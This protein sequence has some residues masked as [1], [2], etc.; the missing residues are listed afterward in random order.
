M[1]VGSRCP[2]VVQVVFVIDTSG[3]IGQLRFQLIREFLTTFTTDL[4][5]NS[6]RNAVGIILF[7]NNAYLEFNLQAYT[8]L[9]ELLLAIRQLPYRGGGTDTAE[10]LTLL[11]ST[12]QNGSL[13]L[14]SDS[15]NIAIVI[16]DGRSNNRSATLSA[17]AALHALNIFDIYTV[18]VDGASLT[19]LLAIASSPDFVFFIN[20]FTPQEIQDR[21][22]PQLCISKYPLIVL[23]SYICVHKTM[24]LEIALKVHTQ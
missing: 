20:S 21:I 13:G 16:T 1:Y 3:S 15:A 6:P 7:G 2:D 17:A 24:N 9:N 23:R 14:R 10:A 19:E 4:I 12:A 22:L 5:Q 18:G 8:T 11:L